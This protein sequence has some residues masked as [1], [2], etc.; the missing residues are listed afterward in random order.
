MSRARRGSVGSACSANATSTNASTRRVPFMLE[1]A[2][3]ATMTAW[4]A[5][6]C[7]WDRLVQAV[8]A[9]VAESPLEGFAATVDGGVPPSVRP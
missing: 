7:A 2:V 3:T 5:D 8:G 4:G 6:F 1:A 9:L